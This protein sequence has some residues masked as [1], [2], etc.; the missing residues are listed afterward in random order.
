MAEGAISHVL[1]LNFDLAVQHAAS[2][3]GT[4]IAIVRQAGQAVPVRSALVHLHGN[5]DSLSDALV[6]RAEVI[7]DAWRGQWEQVVAQQVLGA[8]VVLFV[9]L[10]SAAPVLTA[11]IDMI[12]S[13]LGGNKTLYQADLGPFT[14]NGFAQQLNIPLERYMQYG[15]SVVL[16][17]LAERVAAAQLDSL[18]TNG[19]ALLAENDVSEEDRERFKAL[20]SCLRLMPLLALGKLRA[21]ASLDKRALYQP[22]SARDD[23]II[24]EPMLR[25]AQLAEHYGLEATPT[26]GG[27]WTLTR[28]G[29]HIGQLLLASGGG[30]RRMAALEPRAKLVCGYIE[31]HSAGPDF[32]LIGGMV[33]GTPL[34]EHVD[35]IAD[36]DPADIIDGPSRPVLISADDGDF[37]ERIG[38]LLNAA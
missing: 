12:Q 2:H 28:E 7:D 4:D 23:E 22:H 35:I 34:R 18:E 5:A 31:E 11:T 36:S 32:V 24:A 19:I 20:V 17:K 9:G 33:S 1:S 10:G 16:S 15:W 3:L 29:R 25:L 13:A 6:L 30:T 14:G 37:I 8:P 21:F 27:T 38:E 26:A